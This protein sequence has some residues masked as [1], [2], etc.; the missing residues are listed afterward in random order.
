MYELIRIYDQAD[1]VSNFLR[2]KPFYHFILSFSALY[3]YYFFLIYLYFVANSSRIF[4][5]FLSKPLFILS[6]YYSNAYSYVPAG[7]FLLSFTYPFFNS[8]YAAFNLAYN[9]VQFILVSESS[10]LNLAILLSLSVNYYL[11]FSSS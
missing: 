4:W 5:I 3:S 2:S 9:W 1:K 10:L 6:I 8:A 11:Y 7:G